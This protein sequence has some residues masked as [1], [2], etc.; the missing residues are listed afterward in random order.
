[1]SIYGITVD[2]N[3]GFDVMR[4]K[5]VLRHF[6]RYEDAQAY[7]ALGHGRYVRYWA[8]KGS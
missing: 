1:M 3:R 7:A 4:G 6:E 5:Q 8:V 2:E